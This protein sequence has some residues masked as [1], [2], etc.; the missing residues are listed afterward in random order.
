MSDPWMKFYPRDW[1]GDQSLRAVSIAARGLWIECLCIMHE[2]KPYGHLV[3]NGAPVEDDTLARMTGV[4][5]D[6]VSA[7]MAELRQAG[8]LSVTSRGVVFSRRMTKDHARAQKGRKAANKRWSQ[9]S[10]DVEQSEAPNRSSNGLP[11]TQKPDTRYQKEIEPIAQQTIP[12]APRNRWDELQSACLE[13]AGLSGFRTERSVKL[14]DLSPIRGLL[15]KGYS[16][17]NDILSAIRDKAASGHVFTN[18]AY[19]V[20]IVIERAAK[21]SAIPAK[22]AEPAEDWPGRMKVW[23]ETQTWGAWGPRPGERGCRVP[24]ELLSEAA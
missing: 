9:A 15:E 22:P 5:A 24:P 2:A 13:A 4:S 8:V 6:E 3:L 23:R 12:A 7:L 14:Q 19:I 1:R 17:E 11:T 21:R 18:W 20:P 16:L 10:D